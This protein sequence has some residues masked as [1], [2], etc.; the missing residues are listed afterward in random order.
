MAHSTVRLGHPDTE[1]NR[2]ADRLGLALQFRQG[3]L[4]F[5]TILSLGYVH[6]ADCDA[7]PLALGVA[8]R[9]GIQQPR[10]KAVVRPRRAANLEVVDPRT[11]GD[12]SGEKSQRPVR[13]GG[14]HSI[15][16]LAEARHGRDSTEGGEGW[17]DVQ[18]PKISVEHREAH[19]GGLDQRR[20]R[21]ASESDQIRDGLE[22]LSF[23]VMDAG[24]GPCPNGHQHQRL[25]RDHDRETDGFV[26]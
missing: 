23:Q 25:E 21:R 7:D 11:V 2:L 14:R 4:G 15:Y 5:L 22:A 6:D 17:I 8:K 9:L 19:R 26:V 20:R 13:E 12:D 3:G 1:R 10:P 18:I 24:G 16:A